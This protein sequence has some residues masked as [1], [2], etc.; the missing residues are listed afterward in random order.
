MR[1][2]LL[3]SLVPAPGGDLVLSYA[4]V[5]VSTG[6]RDKS[7]S[8]A[9]G[10]EGTAY[11]IGGEIA[12][13]HDTN[14]DLM[15][16]LKYEVFREMALSDPAVRSLEWLYKLP[17]RSADWSLTPASED[18]LD[19][20]VAD[21][22]AWQFG[23]GEVIPQRRHAI[24]RLSQTWDQSLNQALLSLRYGAHGEELIFSDTIETYVDGDGD[25]HL[26]RPLARLAPR[27]AATVYEYEINARTGEIDW[28]RQDTPKARPIPGDKLAWYVPDDAEQAFWGESL[29]RSAFGAW[30]L[31]R[32][33]LTATAIGWDRYSSG[34]PIVR[35]PT[36][37]GADKLREAENIG[38]NW[39]A[40]ERGWVV[41]EGTVLEG[42]DVEI[43]N[44]NGT[45]PDP[46][47]LLQ[48]YDQQI[49]AAG[50]QQFSALGTTD[51]GSRAVGQV[52]QE[53]YFMALSAIAGMIAQT[54]MRRVF[55]RVIDVNF[56]KDVAVPELTVRKI[57]GKN[58][59]LLAQIIADLSGA[60]LSFTDPGTQ[61]DLRD[62]LDLRHLPADVQKTID[63]LPDD[64]SVE[65]PP[66][67]PT[68]GGQN[69]AG[70]GASIAA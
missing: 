10:G 8:T 60:G 33:M 54:R 18:P 6:V 63:D 70:E 50:I 35:Y 68:P 41:L 39:R 28:I 45:L 66:R 47:P 55:R 30:K 21:F 24:A 31:K 69:P 12:G 25:E 44:G 53:P 61:N 14:P 46:V 38:R 67:L 43:K 17:I 65:V 19:L 32:E 27:F 40:H 3:D 49:A 22:L 4:S 2:P 5:P 57:T 64:V 29:L 37:S 59:S 11:S 26:V 15:G 9:A 34:I 23:L 7:T 62:S 1:I 58:I 36:G 20:F 52:L 42:W 56:G 48:H 16:R 13:G 51:T